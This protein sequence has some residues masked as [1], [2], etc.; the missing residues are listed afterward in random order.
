MHANGTLFVFST[1]ALLP[2][3][4][5][6][7]DTVMP[8]LIAFWGVPALFNNADRNQKAQGGP[9]TG[10]LVGACDTHN[11]APMCSHVC[12]VAL[13]QHSVDQHTRDGYRTGAKL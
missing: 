11:P 9:Q 13:L 7:L 4:L 3:P 5:G 8:H 12:V 1:G 10:L 2:G 6:K